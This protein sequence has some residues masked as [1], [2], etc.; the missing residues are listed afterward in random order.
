MTLICMGEAALI[1]AEQWRRQAE[2]KKTWWICTECCSIKSYTD[3]NHS[4]PTCTACGGSMVRMP[5]DRVE[6]GM[7]EAREIKAEQLAAEQRRHIQRG[8]REW[9]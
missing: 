3:E 1:Q 7:R 9:I 6:D 5:D 8:D 4:W 2:K